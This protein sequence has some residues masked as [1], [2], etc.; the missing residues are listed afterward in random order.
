MRT[1]LYCQTAGGPNLTVAFTLTENMFP[2]REHF[3][4]T[5]YT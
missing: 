1:E 4:R 5:F 3:M 2:Y